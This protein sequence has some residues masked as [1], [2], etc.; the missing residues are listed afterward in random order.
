MTLLESL[1]TL[2]K[3]MGWVKDEFNRYH[4]FEIVCVWGL[5]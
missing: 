2:E 3:I 1:P 5:G 4:H